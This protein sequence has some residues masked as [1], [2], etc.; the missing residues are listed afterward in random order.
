MQVNRRLTI[1]L[2]FTILL[3]SCYEKKE[4]CLDVLAANFN[5][6]ADVDC[7]QDPGTCCCEYPKLSFSI[8]HQFGSENLSR[9]R[10]YT[11]D[12]GQPY[13][14]DTIRFFIS[15]V[16]LLDGN[17]YAVSDT[18]IIKSSNGEEVARPDDV[19]IVSSTSFSIELGDFVRPG[20]YSNLSFVVG[21]TE[22]ERTASY[23]QFESPHPLAENQTRL[24]DSISKSLLLYDVG[25]IPDTLDGAVSHFQ[26][27]ASFTVLINLP[28]E[29]IKEPGKSI[30]IPLGIDYQKWLETLDL[31]NGDPDLQ[32][33]K[34]L[35]GIGQSFS[36]L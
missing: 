15:N 16:R 24:K 10:L 28:V 13:Y 22:P 17:E 34:I 33:Q 30:T 23:D 27:P 18:I 26:L 3:L 12:L 6:E 8:K 1:L 11:T 20:I 31:D 9:G 32:N 25:L 2:L 7:C 21:I 4:G 19:A 5:L 36:I 29:I 35:Q 14:I